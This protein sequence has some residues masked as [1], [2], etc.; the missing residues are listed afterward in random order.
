M[1][2]MGITFGIFGLLAFCNVIALQSRV[3]KLEKQ[4]SQVEGTSFYE[5]R[6]SLAEAVYAYI[7]KDVKIE[8]KEDE[9]DVDILSYGNGKYGKN[10]ILDA[11]EEWMLVESSGPKGTKEKLI[12]ISSVKRIT[13]KIGE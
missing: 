9:P 3:T 2:Y 7:G 4:L 5:E 8:M 11:D 6:K 1:E 13:E 10:V 12:R